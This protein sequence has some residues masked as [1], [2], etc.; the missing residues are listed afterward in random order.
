MAHKYRVGIVGCGGI[1][2]AHMEGYNKLENVEVVAATDP[3]ETAR[4]GYMHDYNIP[5]GYETIQE[6]LDDAQP[7]IVSVCVWHLLHDTV[8]VEL[9]KGK[10]VKGIICEKPMAIG[11]G[12]A[13]RMVE[14]CE[15]NN[16]KLIIS[17]QRRFTPGWEK[18]REIVQKGSI[19]IPLRADL[20]IRDGL[21]NWGSHAIDGARFV[22]NDPKPLWVMG[23]VERNSEKYERGTV[24]EDSCMGLIHFEDGLQFFLQSDLWD[25]N[26]DAGKFFIRGTEGMIHITETKVKLFNE[27]SNGWKD[28]DLDLKEG[29]KAIGG[30]SNASQT[31]ELIEW[32]E[33]GPEHR[34]SGRKGRDTVEIMMAIYESARFNKVIHLPMKEKEYPLE[35]MIE[36]EKLPISIKGKYDIRGFLDWA[37]I[38]IEKYQRLRDDGLSHSESMNTLRLYIKEDLN[39]SK[40]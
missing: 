33:G 25:N 11:M 4:N 24:I 1:G 17:H 9:A 10:S 39:K 14:V 29:D 23:S 5:N 18:A 22:L 30:N 32:I 19:G 13:D 7:E 8:T 31:T 40:Y 16:V 38:D 27:S 20:R 2:N 15:E 36:E 34:C 3:V 21:S 6:M 37:K 12:R 35:K 26:C 28:I